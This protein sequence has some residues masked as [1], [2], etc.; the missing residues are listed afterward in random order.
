MQPEMTGPT[1][2]RQAIDATNRRF[3]AALG[4]GDP[5]R[6]AREV[7][8]RDAVVLPPGAPL[9]RGLESIEKFW[10]AAVQQLGIQGVRLET[11]ELDAHGDTAHEIG[12][13]T[14]RLA[15]GGEVVAKYV[16]VW[17][18]RDGDWRWHVDIWNTDE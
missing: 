14:L 15:G 1:H 5:A 13:G 4:A 18:R 8:T 11:I 16:V 9:M 7:Y 12:R 3:E 10:T 6:A 2:V 17:K